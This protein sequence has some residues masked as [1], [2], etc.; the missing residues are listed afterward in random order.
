MRAVRLIGGLALALGLMVAALLAAVLLIDPN[1]FEAQ[2]EAAASR[3]FDRPI[4]LDGTIRW[5]PSLHP[6]LELEGLTVGNPDWAAGPYLAKVGRVQ[7]RVSLLPLLRGDLHVEQV[8]FVDVDLRLE[9]DEQGRDNFTFG[10][11][12]DPTAL[13]AIE[14]FSLRQ[15]AIAYQP[16]SGEV[17]QFAVDE[18]EV[19]NT[20]G[21]ER[22]IDLTGSVDQRPLRIQTRVSRQPD[23]KD[24]DRPWRVTG[25]LTLADTE[26][27]VEGRAVHPRRLEEGDYRYQLKGE[28]L[29]L[30]STLLGQEVLG[31]GPFDVAGELSS[32]VDPTS[33][34]WQFALSAT[35]Q[36]MKL[37][38]E[39]AATGAYTLDGLAVDFG[40]EGQDVGPL[41][42]LLEIEGDWRGAYRLQGQIA[43][44][45][46]ARVLPWSVQAELKAL[47]AKLELDAKLPDPTE[48]EGGEYRFRASGEELK[49]L[50]ILAGGEHLGAGSFEL[51]GRMDA[52]GLSAD[53]DLKG[54]DAGALIAVLGAEGDLEGSYRLKGRIAKEP[55]AKQRP[56]TVKTTLSAADA[57]LELDG[58]LAAPTIPEDGEYRF[59]AK[60]ERLSIFNSFTGGVPA[61]EGKFDFNGRLDTSVDPESGRWRLDLIGEG[62]RLNARLQGSADRPFGHTGLDMKFQV[63][64][65]EVGSVLPLLNLAMNLK[66]AYRLEGRLVDRD[67]RYQFSD[68][69]MRVGKT[70][71]SG[72]LSIV[73]DRKP[74]PLFVGKL[75]S[76]QLHLDDLELFPKDEAGSKAEGDERLIPDYTLPVELADRGD[77]D[78]EFKADKVV[79]ELGELGQLSLH[80]TLNDGRF[81]LDPIAFTG[82]DGGK[83]E[84]RLLADGQQDPPRLE[85]RWQATSLNY[86]S[87]LQHAGVTDLVEGRVDAVFE[88]AGTGHTRRELLGNA[89]GSF[90]LVGEKG[91]FASRKLDLWGSDLLRIM[92]SDRWEKEDITELNCVVARIAVEDG[93]ARSDDIIVDTERMTLAVTGALTL[94]SEEMDLLLIPR[95][96]RTHLLSLANPA[97]VTGTLS[98]PKVKQATLPK[99]RLAVAGTGALAGLVNPAFLVFTFSKLG[100]AEK[101]P[102]AAAV[103]EADA[104]S[105]GIGLK[106]DQAPKS[107]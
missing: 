104:A 42:R 39:G 82:W 105:A 27:S 64:G 71:V 6:T 13:P 56:W 65:D 53:F 7:T 24:E 83:V 20:P 77:M 41:M 67:D 106:V 57:T 5:T 100:S 103:K 68:L 96:K 19:E 29:D 72:D 21:R 18:V 45:S 36:G 47:N 38:A 3:A 40:L 52:K 16:A 58:R 79:M 60:G 74:R 17:R 99:K 102:C 90:V 2:I 75:H 54:N 26:L 85:T 62:L 84:A 32:S 87:L 95:P 101:N 4:D 49:V 23:V 12:D 81:Q 44:Q 63:D 33:R 59:H 37:S 15:A 14:R 107:N 78:I 76:K 46:D 97:Q 86:G 88:L 43:Q 92:L 98:S 10:D 51:Q 50:E 73:H 31:T 91:R 35:G 69:K 22:S 70:D 55:Q 28:R 94:E 8:T 48:L 80:A 61:G 9:E 89:S 34:Q 25:T 11:P 1:A 66:G 93:V 30:L